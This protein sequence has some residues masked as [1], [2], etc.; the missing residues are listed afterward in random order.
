[1]HSDESVGRRR[2]SG[3]PVTADA[4]DGGADRQTIRELCA[5]SVVLGSGGPKGPYP[6]NS[7]SAERRG[8]PGRGPA[9]NT[10]LISQPLPSFRS[11]H[12]RKN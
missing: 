7:L 2:C 6:N 5:R 9:P 11:S 10:T 3:R 8:Q 12:V 4:G 1:M